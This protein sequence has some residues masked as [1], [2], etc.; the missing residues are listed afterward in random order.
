MLAGVL[1]AAQRR[2]AED[3]VAAIAR[4]GEVRVRRT[5][6]WTSSE[7]DVSSRQVFVP[8]VFYTALDYLVALH[9]LAHILHRSADTTSEYEPSMGA[10]LR[11]EAAAW[12]W[13]LDRAKPEILASMTKTDRRR[14]GL[15]WASHS[16]P[17]WPNAKTGALP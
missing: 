14:M 7:A 9:E 2:L 6:R 3:H 5:K 15:C 4:R 10:C 8:K 11:I 1:S 17:V 16:G 13:A 12:G